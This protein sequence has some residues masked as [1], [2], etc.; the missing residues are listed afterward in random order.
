[1]KND[2][3]SKIDILLTEGRKTKTIKVTKNFKTRKDVVKFID[4]LKDFETPDID[5]FD[6]DT[7]EILMSRGDTKHEIK[8]YKKKSYKNSH[9]DDEIDVP[10]LT[11]GYDEDEYDF[12][13][14]YNVVTKPISKLVDDPES[15]SAKDYDTSTVIPVALSRKDGLK[16]TNDDIDNIKNY[17]EYKNNQIQEFSSNIKIVIIGLKV[18]KK[19]VKFSFNLN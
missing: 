5:L 19:R 9:A 17:I 6:P 12:N 15:L 13:A 10:Y 8:K 11:F 7:G 1:M 18:N 2:I 16:F 3:I 14:F 4:T